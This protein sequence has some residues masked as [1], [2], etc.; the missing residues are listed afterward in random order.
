LIGLASAL[1]VALI[2]EHQEGDR[3]VGKDVER[4][5]VG[6]SSTGKYQRGMFWKLVGKPTLPKATVTTILYLLLMPI[7]VLITALFRNIIG[8][9]TVGT[10]TPTLLA[11]SQVRGDWRTGVVIFVLVFGLGS[12]CRKLCEKLNLTT[13]SR[14]GLVLIFVVMALVGS[15][16]ACEILGLETMPR[17]VLLPVAVMTLLVERFFSLLS[18]GGTSTAVRVLCNTLLV[19]V[20]C[21]FA[22]SY[23]PVRAL[24]LGYP[25]LEL[26]LAGGLDCR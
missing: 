21:F 17:A 14:R 10:F 13:I 15:I 24:V 6:V 12:I 20:C 2:P 9:E 19:A 23:A 18:E 11:L 5:R 26:C 1:T 16:I 25:E 7:G 22:F 3:L 8:I 4:P